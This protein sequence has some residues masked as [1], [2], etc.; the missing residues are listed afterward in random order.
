[1]TH[2][3]EGILSRTRANPNETA[4]EAAMPPRAWG[5]LLPDAVQGLRPP[6]TPQTLRRW[7]HPAHPRAWAIGVPQTAQPPHHQGTMKVK[8]KGKARGKGTGRDTR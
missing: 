7:L 3:F 2:T 8:G 4:P 6:N 5:T 1:M